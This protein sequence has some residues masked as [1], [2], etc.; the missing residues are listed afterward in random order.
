MTAATKLAPDTT[1]TLPPP[2][3]LPELPDTPPLAPELTGPTLSDAALSGAPASPAVQ[4]EPEAPPMTPEQIIGLVAEVSAFG[5]PAGISQAYKDDFKENPIVNLGV[6]AS[7]LAEALAAYGVTAGGGKLPEWLSVLLGVGVLGY[8][9]Y[10]TRSKYVQPVQPFPAAA[11]E[12]PAGDFGVAGV[13]TPLST[14][15]I[16]FSNAG[17]QGAGAVVTP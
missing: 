16:G 1:V 11:E 4:E 7:G 15:N 6:H 5:L 13:S 9:I 8:G 14:T 3:P 17:F 12:T 2:G 10:A